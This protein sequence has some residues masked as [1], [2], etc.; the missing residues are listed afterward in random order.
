MLRVLL[1]ACI[2]P[3]VVS[4]IVTDY[5]PTSTEYNYSYNVIDLATGDA[6]TLHEVRQ[7]DT[8]SGSYS[9]IDPDGTRRTVTYIAGPKTGFKAVIHKEPAT[10]PQIANNKNYN[11]FTAEQLGIIQTSVHSRIALALPDAATCTR[12]GLCPDDKCSR[13]YACRKRS[14]SDLDTPRYPDLE[15]QNQWSAVNSENK[16]DKL[17]DS[18]GVSSEGE[19]SEGVGSVGVDSGVGVGVV[20]GT[21]AYTDLEL[22]DDADVVPLIGDV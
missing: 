20:I 6:K 14:G 11:Y 5:P 10:M 12:C 16:V 1:C 3:V 22:V 9:L 18:K 2:V 19:G 4:I 8:V 7:G 15:M 17:L 21:G 13:Q